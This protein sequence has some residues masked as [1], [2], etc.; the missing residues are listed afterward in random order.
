MR[1]R[2]RALAHEPSRDHDRLAG[3]ELLP[4]LPVDA[5]ELDARDAN[6][7]APPL[8]EAGAHL[9]GALLE[10]ELLVVALDR[11]GGSAVV[12]DLA[13][14]QQHG[15]LAKPLDRRRGVRHE[16]RPFRRAP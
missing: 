2:H 16:A 11:L 8:A 14:A 10:R 4:L 9:L 7:A 6:L 12:L 15:A 5:H 3:E 13:L 1:R